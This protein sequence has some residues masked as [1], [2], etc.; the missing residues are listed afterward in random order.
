M[1]H[2]YGFRATRHGYEPDIAR[3]RR[4]NHIAFS[5]G[6]VVDRGPATAGE[7]RELLDEAKTA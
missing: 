4:S 3:R 5:S 7:L 1:R 6:D 2:A